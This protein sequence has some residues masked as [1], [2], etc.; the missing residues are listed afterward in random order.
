[1]P[2]FLHLPFFVFFPVVIGLAKGF[3]GLSGAIFTQLYYA[4][5]FPDQVSVG[6]C[7]LGKGVRDAY[8]VLT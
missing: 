2:C 6:R 7:I 5:F 1:M 3:T 4:A 8:L